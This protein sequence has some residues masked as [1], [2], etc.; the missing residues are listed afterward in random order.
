MSTMSPFTHQFAVDHLHS[1]PQKV[2]SVCDVCEEA[3]G[4][5]LENTQVHMCIRSAQILANYNMRMNVKHSGST[6]WSAVL[7]VR[8]LYKIL[9]IFLQDTKE[10]PASRWHWIGQRCDHT[11]SDR[12]RKRL[13]RQTLAHVFNMRGIWRL[14]K[15]EVKLEVRTSRLMR[16]ILWHRRSHQ[17]PMRVRN[18]SPSASVC[19]PFALLKN[20]FL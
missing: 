17:D 19:H 14:N 1:C 8:T 20:C 4:V 11:G 16:S 10:P 12:F 3:A 15:W 9:D 13:H 2:I 7:R 18:W 5:W 6:C